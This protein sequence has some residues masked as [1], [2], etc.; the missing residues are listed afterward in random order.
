MK[1]SV[2]ICTHSLDI[3]EHLIE[4]VESVRSQTYGN[5]ELI[6]VVDGNQP[7]YDQM[8]EDYDS[9]TIL[10]NNE[11]LGLSK[12]R[13]RGVERSSGDVIAFLDDDAVADDQWIEQLASVYEH[14]DAIA[15]GGKMVGDWVS[16]KPSFL[17]EEFL[18]LV[19][20]THKGFA[21]PG[22]E[23]RNTFGSNI[24]F[25]REVF[26][27]IG[28]FDPELGR[29]GSLNIQAEETVFCVRMR[30]NFDQ[31][32]VYNPAAVVDHKIFEYRTK[33]SWLFERAF[34]Q[35]YSKR[36]MKHLISQRSE[37]ETEFLK[38]LLCEFVPTRLFGLIREP[39]VSKLIQL[40][41]VIAFTVTVGLGYGY[42]VTRELK[43]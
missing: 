31:G 36:V 14:R 35:G 18:W 34:F 37:N 23:V 3:Y 24:S 42:A 21:E 1:F 13:N 12:S 25:R 7:L 20:V 38:N 5:V 16:G 15:V 17:P 43:A 4:A 2:V 32:V 19:G 11:N 8:I 29:R 40:L 9:V 39:T 10:H 26:E 41:S 28:D 30:E 27:E 33:T 22:E 6:V